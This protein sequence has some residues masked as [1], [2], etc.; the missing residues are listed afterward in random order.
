VSATG[1][2][3]QVSASE[4]EAYYASMSAA[5]PDDAYFELIIF[6]SWPGTGALI[7][8]SRGLRVLPPLRMPWCRTL[9]GG[10]GRT[11]G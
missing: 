3:A 10:T 8:V 7:A 11:G 1:I 4:F 2:A 5:V 6:G 9:T